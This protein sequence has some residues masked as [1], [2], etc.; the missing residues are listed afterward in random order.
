MTI[1]DYISKNLILLPPFSLEPETVMDIAELSLAM[2]HC[3]VFPWAPFIERSDVG[4]NLATECWTRVA[5]LNKRKNARARE[6]I[7]R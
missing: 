6:L 1:I 2:D 4:T 3:I 7:E 5:E